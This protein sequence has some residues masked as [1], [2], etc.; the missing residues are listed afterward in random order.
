MSTRGRPATIHDNDVVAV[1]GLKSKSLLQAESERR[2]VVM[3][4]IDMGGRA[5]V[6]EL[7]E[8][9]GYDL[10]ARLRAL[11]SSGWLVHVAAQHWKGALPRRPK[12]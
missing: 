1:S 11:V 10:T 5:R 2:A 12:A 3:R 8:S 4:L 6:L 7:N 9:F